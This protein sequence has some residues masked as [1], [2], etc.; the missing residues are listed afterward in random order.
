MAVRERHGHD[1]EGPKRDED[2]QGQDTPVIVY[3]LAGGGMRH[4]SYARPKQRF[5]MRT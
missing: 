3:H 5:T 1:G 4:E 2:R